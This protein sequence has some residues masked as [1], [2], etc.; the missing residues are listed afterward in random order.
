MRIRS[1]ENKSSAKFLCQHENVVEIVA[2]GGNLTKFLRKGPQIV[3]AL[4]PSK[5]LP[6]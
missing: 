3:A 6:T 4:R 2:K 5:Y 1:S